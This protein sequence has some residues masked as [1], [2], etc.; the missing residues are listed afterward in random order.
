MNEHLMQ[1]LNESFKSRKDVNKT[2]CK[3]Q[4]ISVHGSLIRETKSKE[5]FVK[6]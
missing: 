5:H 3:Q 1:S 6:Y 2:A 4:V